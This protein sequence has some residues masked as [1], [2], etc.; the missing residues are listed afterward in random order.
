MRSSIRWSFFL[1]LLVTVAVAATRAP[2]GR[3]KNL[4]ILT[5]DIS[6]KKMDSIM[7][8]YSKALGIGCSFCHADHASIADSLDYASDKNEMKLNARNMMKLTIDINQKYFYYDSSIAPIYLNTVHCKTCH[9][10]EPYP[11]E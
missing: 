3:Y 4:Q 5:K 11:V 7:D 6:E 8:S 2:Q 10:G 1:L 9:R